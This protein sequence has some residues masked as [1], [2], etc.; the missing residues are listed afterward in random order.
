MKRVFVTFV[1]VQLCVHLGCFEGHSSSSSLHRLQC[2]V[3]VLCDD[4]TT[5]QATVIHFSIYSAVIV[6]DVNIAATMFIM[7]GSHSGQPLQLN[8]RT[9]EIA[10]RFKN[11]DSVIFGNG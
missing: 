8:G 5:L 7:S 10:R 9:K 11:L 4:S 6:L 1:A 3:M 2:Y